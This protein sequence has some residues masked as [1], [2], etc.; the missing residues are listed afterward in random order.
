MENQPA[1]PDLTPLEFT[2]EHKKTLGP[3]EQTALTK[4]FR[5]Y[6]KNNDGTMD[7]NE[8]KNIM[9]DL[10]YRK[11]TDDK[12]KEML[13][14]QD[15]NKDGVLSWNEFVAMMVKMKG[16]DDGRFGTIIEGKSGAVAQ[17]T[18][19]HGGVHSYS[20]EERTTYAK[21]INQV[22]KDDEDCKDRVPMNPDDDTIF[23][24]FD[25]GIL[26]CKLLLQVDPECIDVRVLNRQNNM[27][28]YQIQ[29]NLKL[30]IAAAKG[31]GI[32]MVG[33]NYSDFINKTPHM[34]LGCL[35]QSIRLAISKHVNLKDTPEILRLAEEG[36]ELKDLLKLSPET[37]LIRWINYHLDK[38]G[39]TKK[40]QNLG[41][42][43]SDSTALFYVLNRLDAEKCPLEGINE[44]DL[45]KRAEKMI[46]NSL[47]LGVPDV[48]SPKHITTGNV[49]VNTLFVSYIF[50]TK[51]GLELTEEEYQ[52]AGMI[53][54]DI[55]GSKEERIFRLW[56]NSLNI[57][58][59]YVND[60]FDDIKDGVLLN[61]VI[62]KID[63]KVVDWG[64]ID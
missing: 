29:E 12:V 53:D 19:K 3:Q 32:K 40:I 39:Q 44:E 42:D 51:H 22:L 17:I 13:A 26:L 6:D 28:V 14:E 36:E 4:S 62:H 58:D 5:N 11:I 2:L 48:V 31:L 52:A 25:N 64:K 50:N 33:V 23:H 49:K 9:I 27:N 21:I 8:F 59:V 34:V 45:E 15:K 55:E 1:K 38:A 7:E 20:I 24:M 35:W 57:D 56:I 18:G 30:G 61:K 63:D 37:I 46:T 16:T 41:K 47:A 10:G 43:L 54:D 60:L